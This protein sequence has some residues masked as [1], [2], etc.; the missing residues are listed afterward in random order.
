[1]S[2]TVTRPRQPRLLA[3]S[4]NQFV[5]KDTEVQRRPVNIFSADKKYEAFIWLTG[6]D[7]FGT[8]SLTPSNTRTSLVCLL[9]SECVVAI[10]FSNSV[11]N[12][13]VAKVDPSQQA[14]VFYSLAH[15]NMGQSKLFTKM[16]ISLAFR[17]RHRQ[18]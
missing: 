8:N 10:C 4:T 1:M 15:I 16:R 3:L 18:T 13:N 11:K 12:P 17:L 14:A 6:L 9:S 7:S 5:P 2:W